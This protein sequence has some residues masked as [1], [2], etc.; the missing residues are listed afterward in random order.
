M[1]KK[2]IALNSIFNMAYKGFTAL[3]P[4]LTTTYIARTLLPGKVGLVSY[5]NTIVV[6]FTTIASLGIPNYGVKEISK[7]GE[8][9]KERSKTFSELFSINFISTSICIALY[10]FFV[11]CFPYFQNQKPVLNIMGLMLVFNLFNVDWFY[12]GI[13][14]YGIIATR[15][16]VVKIVSFMA[17][18]LFVKKPED[19]L[20]YAF[21]LCMAT[22]GNY[23][24]NMLILGKYVAFKR[25]ILN[26]KHHL[27]PVFILLAS[28]IATELY[29]ALDTVMLEYF[30]GS[31][32]VAYYSNATKIVRMIY[33]MV[34]AF[35]ATFYPRI[36]YYI[37]N[38]K[39]NESNRLVEKGFDIIL[40][41]ALPCAVG[42]MSTARYIVLILFGKQYMSSISV[43][44][45][46]SILVFIFSVAYMLGHIILMASGN[47]KYILR[48]TIAGAIVNAVLNA[49]LIPKYAENGAIIASVI[50]EITVT[51]VL[52]FYSRKH[53]SLS[54]DYAFF[55]SIGF[56]LLFMTIGIVV[57]K[58]Y[59]LF[60]N[61]ILIQFVEIVI[62]AVFIYG[63]T[64]IV[65][66]N[67]LIIEAM[68]MYTLQI[69]PWN[70]LIKKALIERE[71]I[72]FQEQFYCGE[73]FAFSVECFQ[74]TNKV[75]VGHQNVYFYRIDNA[76]SGSSTFSLGKYNS[77]VNAQDYMRNVLK[78]KSQYADNVLKFSK[79]RTLSDNFTLLKASGEE[80]EY[81][82][83]YREM[84]HEVKKGALS[85]FKIPVKSKQKLRA[86]V[87]GVSPEVAASIFS[88]YLNRKMGGKF[89]KNTENKVD[90]Q[91]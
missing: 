63:A 78:D 89:K 62:A 49:C 80:K 88:G 81:S 53:F 40:L 60:S 73:G 13:E 31:A 12:Q 39:K 85:A 35:V 44:K 25:Y 42:L 67:R 19:Y 51:S 22:A 61:S 47:E 72:Y 20:K 4:L 70:K 74:S 37:Q 48:A 30:H 21:I 58:K 8:N 36:A 41:M 32:N 71:G 55:R 14:E 83:I 27:K 6:Y 43:L 5:A 59:L 15:G 75:V 84:K 52:I 24:F 26:I 23:I 1:A 3:F 64:L 69:G 79:W 56:S 11:N 90:I 66:R 16:T 54:K 10:Y 34:I 7:C 50:S 68:L 46:A 28:S 86:F 87:F 33:T 38:N 45:I 57:I 76:T 18:L 82:A 65:T 77:S 17:M 9:V 91:D 2:S 29:M